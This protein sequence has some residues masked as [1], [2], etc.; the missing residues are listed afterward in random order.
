MV[1]E[2]VQLA[3][4]EG[5]ASRLEVAAAWLEEAASMAA[6]CDFSGWPCEVAT[7]ASSLGELLDLAADLLVTVLASSAS[8]LDPATV[9]SGVSD[10]AP[11]Y[12]RQFVLATT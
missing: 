7:V 3:S 5:A 6:V 1:Q 8:P 9:P 10:A 4:L 2:A 12:A 11:H